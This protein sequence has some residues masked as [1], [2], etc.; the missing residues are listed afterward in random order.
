MKTLLT[1]G[2]VAVA[3]AGCQSRK[4]ISEM[5]YT[6]IKDLA[7]VINQRCLDQGVKPEDPQWQTCTKQEISRENATR[8]RARQVADSTV[9]CNRVG[10][11]TICN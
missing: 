2:F 9:I 3:L 11:A 4:Q 1:I 5:S 10:T 7:A 6:E 8:V